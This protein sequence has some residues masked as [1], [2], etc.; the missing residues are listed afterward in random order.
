MKPQAQNTRRHEMFSLIE[1]Y[2][3]SGQSQNQ[4]CA[5]KKLPKSTFLYWLKKYRS[6]KSPASGFIPLHFSP[7]RPAPRREPGRTTGPASHSGDY[8][9]ELPNG[10]R[11]QLSGPEGL[12]LIADV[13]AQTA[14][15]DVSH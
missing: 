4:F 1:E 10:I 7:P 11:I 5:Q 12:E 15:R 2:R 6:D 13:I 8:R 14:G 9:L 3:H